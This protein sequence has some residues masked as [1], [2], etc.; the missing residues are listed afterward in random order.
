MTLRVLWSSSAARRFRKLPPDVQARIAPRIEALAA[1]P[2]PP[3]AKPVH[4]A[5]RGV[6]RIR[7]GD[8]RVVYQVRG[9]EVVVLILTVGHRSDVY[10]RM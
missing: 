4:G 10:D 2:H 9:T 3:D 8:Y 6:S 7:V 1:D 5:G